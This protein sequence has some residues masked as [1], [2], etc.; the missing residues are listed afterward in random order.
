MAD[1]IVYRL[2]R[3]PEKNHLAF[4]D[5]VGITL[6]PPSAAR[7]DVTFWLSAPQPRTVVLPAG[8]RGGHRPHRERGGGR[9]RHRATN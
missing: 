7:A 6:F 2:N 1:Q 9:L 3:V 4:L 8:H 5:L